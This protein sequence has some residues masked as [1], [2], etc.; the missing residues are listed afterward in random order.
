MLPPMSPSPH[1]LRQTLPA[2]PLPR[3]RHAAPYWAIV[4]AGGYEEA[5]DHGR[6]RVSAGDLIAHGAF[7]AHLN[8]FAPN[9]ATVL[10]LPTEAVPPQAFGRLADVDAVVRLVERDPIQAVALILD[11]FEAIAPRALD[12]PDQLAAALTQDPSA[13]I[14]AWARARGLSGEHVARGFRQVFGVSPRRF[15][16]EARARAALGDLIHGRA[17]LAGVAAD[18]GFTDQA[19]MSRAV[20]AVTGRTPGLWRRSTA[21][22][23]GT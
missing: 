12:W 3:H 4:L 1:P 22:K 9:G 20:Q 7:E 5:G 6:R 21:Y 10:N 16:L 13:E 11:G 17:S 8:R 14:G 18:R 19:H 15:R 2:D 23:T